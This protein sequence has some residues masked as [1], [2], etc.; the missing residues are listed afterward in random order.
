MSRRAL[1]PRRTAALA[2]APV[3]V[4]DLTC[5]VV[6]GFE[7]RPFREFLS[8]ERVAHTR[9]G[10]H[11]VARVEDVL[12]ALDRL[13]VEQ[14]EPQRAGADDQEHD[15]DEPRSVA[16]VLRRIGGRRVA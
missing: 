12:E 4:T 7:A 1:R 15:A 14:G 5:A 16:D 10:R 2:V 8:R 9:L 13:R 3:T 11:V 6:L